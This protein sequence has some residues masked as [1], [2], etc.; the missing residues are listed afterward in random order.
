MFD[1]FGSESA[2]RERRF[3]LSFSP[4]LARVVLGGRKKVS[5]RIDQ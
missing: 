3:Y 1:H 2:D 4:L 5:E